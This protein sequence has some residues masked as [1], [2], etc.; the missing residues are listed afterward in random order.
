MDKNMMHK[1]ISRSFRSP[2]D[3]ESELCKILE[4]RQSVWDEY[5][6]IPETRLGK[7]INI[8]IFRKFSP[9]YRDEGPWGREKRTYFSEATFIPSKEASRYYFNE[10]V[11]LLKMG[12]VR[13]TGGG[14]GSGKTSALLL[15]KNLLHNQDLIIDTSLTNYEE[16]CQQIQACHK[17]GNKVLITWIFTEFSQAIQNMIDRAIRFGRCIDI[18]RMARLHVGSKMV[19]MN[20]IK[21]HTIISEGGPF[22]FHIIDGYGKNKTCYDQACGWANGSLYNQKVLDKKLRTM[23]SSLKIEITANF[24]VGLNNHLHL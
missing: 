20:A 11:N 4:N 24:F 14:P 3:V 9:E 19:A 15:E 16:V 7:I 10:R 21:N 6:R 17:G 13:F 5:C 23:R 2:I 12:V 1:E 8:D 22:D 18:E